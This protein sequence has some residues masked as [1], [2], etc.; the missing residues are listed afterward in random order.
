MATTIEAIFDGEVFRP[1]KSI[2]IEPNTTVIL[3]VEAVSE[4]HSKTKSF[5]RTTRDLNLQGPP[6]WAS[7]LD[8]YL[9]SEEPNGGG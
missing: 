8:K 4:T 6:D 7:N 9:Y 5:L 2:A 3:T 1:S